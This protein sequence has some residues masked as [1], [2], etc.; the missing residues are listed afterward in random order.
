MLSASRGGHEASVPHAALT[1][2]RIRGQ[3]EAKDA[4]DWKL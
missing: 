2:E 4:K 1:A 3:A